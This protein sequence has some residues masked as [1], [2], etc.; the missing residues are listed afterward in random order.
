MPR[1]HLDRSVKRRKDGAMPTAP[2][3]AA[4]IELHYDTFGDRDGPPLLL[5]MGLGAQMIVWDQEFCEAL[6][7]R[8]FFVVRFDNRDVG[9]STKLTSA[10]IDFFATIARAIQGEPI[11][12]PYKLSDMA[13]DAVSLLDHLGI[14]AAHIVGA[15]MGGMIAQTIAIEHPARVLTL[16]SIMSTTGEQDVGQ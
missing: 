14:R 6:A 9:L 10:R 16:T 4:G 5:I 11:D 13:A 3:N 12:S 7:D 15:S 2:P 8:G 1:H